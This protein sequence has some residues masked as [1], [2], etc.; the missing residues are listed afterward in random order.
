MRQLSLAIP[1]SPSLEIVDREGV[2]RAVACTPPPPEDE[3]K[4]YLAF[5]GNHP[6]LQ[7]SRTFLARYDYAPRYLFSD[8]GQLQVGPIEEECPF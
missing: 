5:T 8:L 1:A 3:M 2:C 6:P 4:T 7:A